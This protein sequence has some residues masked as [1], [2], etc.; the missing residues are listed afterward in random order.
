MTEPRLTAEFRVKAL[1]RRGGAVGVQVVLVRRGDATAGSVLL[2]V[3]RFGAGV[4]VLTETRDPQGAAA[5][6][7][8]TGAAP[9]SEAVADAYIDRARNR[10]PDLWVVEVEDPE[11]KLA[12]DEAILD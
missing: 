2:K 12:L 9:V 5:W 4:R 10:D 11:G 6:M 7:S 8:G 3:N 1:I